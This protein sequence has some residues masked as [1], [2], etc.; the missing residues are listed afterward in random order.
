MHNSANVLT[1]IVL[2]AQ[3]VMIR[4]LHLTHSF[5]T[6]TPSS[7]LSQYFKPYQFGI[8]TELIYN[9][10]LLP[11]VGFSMERVVTTSQHVI[12][13]EHMLNVQPVGC[14]NCFFGVKTLLTSVVVE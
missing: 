2:F 5:D 3:D 6:C 11:I 10:F 7:S 9:G 4:W 14:R 12:A 1:V 8:S 13:V